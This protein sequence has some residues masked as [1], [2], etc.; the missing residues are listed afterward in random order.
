MHLYRRFGHAQFIGD[1]LVEQAGLDTAHD[2][3][4]GWG[5]PWRSQGRG[6]RRPLVLNA[7][8]VRIRGDVHLPSPCSDP[9]IFNELL[10]RTR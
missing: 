10:N 8:A 9:E 7:I 6:R 5:E 3:H 4:L 1:L 2:L